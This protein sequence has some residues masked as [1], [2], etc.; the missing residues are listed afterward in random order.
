MAEEDLRGKW[1]GV[2]KAPGDAKDIG[3]GEGVVAVHAVMLHTGKVLL[4]NSRY[5]GLELLYAAWTWNPKTGAA[6]EDLPFDGVDSTGPWQ[7]GSDIDIFCAHHVVLE[8][9]RVMVLGG[10]SGLNQEG[11][12]HGADGVWIFDPEQGDDGEWTKIADMA[13]VD[14]IQRP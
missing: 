8:D 9:G 10:A 13:M 14:G 3:D 1:T 7:P 11:V 4:W 2:Q 5:E 6:S 12:S